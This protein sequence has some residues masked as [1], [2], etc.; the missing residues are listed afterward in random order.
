T[1]LQGRKL[2]LRAYMPL[3]TALAQ[4]RLSSERSLVYVLR[5]TGCHGRLTHGSI[6]LTPSGGLNVRTD[7]GVPLEYLS[8]DALRSWCVLSEHG[9][10]LEEWNM[11]LPEDEPDIASYAF[12]VLATRPTLPHL[13]RVLF[14]PPAD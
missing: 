5:G 11:M 12:A 3:E 2:L 14:A 6:G 4:L 8:G 9:M 13:P 10:I 1:S 7:L